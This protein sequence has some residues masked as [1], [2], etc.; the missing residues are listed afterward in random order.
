MPGEQF[1]PNRREFLTG[2]IA[3]AGM[4]GYNSIYMYIRE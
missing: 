4:L 2:A 1:N 3:V